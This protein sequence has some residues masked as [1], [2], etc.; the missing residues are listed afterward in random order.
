MELEKPRVIFLV[1]ES[2]NFQSRK[3]IPWLLSA[4]KDAPRENGLLKTLMDT[5]CISKVKKEIVKLV[6]QQPALK[7][8]LNVT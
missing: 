8:N 6:A 2:L 4:K 1:M 5:V 7:C 3:E